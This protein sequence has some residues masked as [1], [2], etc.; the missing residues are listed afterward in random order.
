MWREQLYKQL[1]TG[2]LLK[3]FKSLDQQK[4]GSD[5][6]TNTIMII[7]RSTWLRITI[8]HHHSTQ[9]F[10]RYSLVAEDVFK[11]IYAMSSKGDYYKFCQPCIAYYTWLLGPWVKHKYSRLYYLSGW[12]ETENKSPLSLCCTLPAASNTCHWL[13]RNKHTHACTQIDGERQRQ[14]NKER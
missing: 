13:K 11:Y 7:I 2:Q 5:A 10:Y 3:T 9:K 8:V 12:A 14:T 1:V 6:E 4:P